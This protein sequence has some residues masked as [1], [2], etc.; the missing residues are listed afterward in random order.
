LPT[1]TLTQFMVNDSLLNTPVSISILDEKLIHS[2]NATEISWVLNK[3][4]GVFMQS[5]S[6]NTNRISIR[7][8]GARTPYGTSRIRGFYGSIPLTSGQSE[9]TIDDLD[10]EQIGQVEII[11]GPMS[12]IFG[13][14]LG[15]AI[16][17]HPKKSKRKGS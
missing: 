3:A 10:L 9:T 17:L 1:A 11:N 6:I 16:L 12:S 4:P 14:G 15:G 13:A 2:N 8:L 7:G 5:G